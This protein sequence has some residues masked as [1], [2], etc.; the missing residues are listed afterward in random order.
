MTRTSLTSYFI[1]PP[2][3]DEADGPVVLD[4]VP[5]PGGL[6]GSRTGMTVL[7]GIK[8]AL[9]ELSRARRAL[10]PGARLHSVDIRVEIGEQRRNRLTK[11]EILGGSLSLVPDR[12]TILAE[13]GV[14]H[15]R[16]RHAQKE[17]EQPRIAYVDLTK[18]I[19]DLSYDVE[20]MWLQFC[21]EH[22]LP[23]EVPFHSVLFTTRHP[24]MVDLLVRRLFPWVRLVFFHV[25]GVDDRPLPVANLYSGDPEFVT[26]SG[27]T[28]GGAVALPPR[29]RAGGAESQRADKEADER[30]APRARRGRPR[31]AARMVGIASAI[32]AA[33][34]EAVP[35]RLAMGDAHQAEAARPEPTRPTPTP[36][37]SAET[38]AEPSGL[39]AKAQ[40]GRS[41]ATSEVQVGSAGSKPSE[42][43]SEAVKRAP[44]VRADVRPTPEPERQAASSRESRAKA[45]A[46]AAKIALELEE[47]ARLEAQQREE[48]MAEA[49]AAR[50]PRKLQELMP[51]RDAIERARQSLRGDHPAQESGREGQVKG[52]RRL[53]GEHPAPIRVEERRSGDRSRQLTLRRS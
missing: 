4:N 30:A 41:A 1:L 26:V 6:A 49:A 17:P 38:Q 13:A 24:W 40:A 29:L 27:R 37:M 34:D 44:V 19:A 43:R 23:L 15:R 42:R 11:E 3:V 8:P 45:N 20:A 39:P 31:K 28:Y 21:K 9:G 50:H 16:L 7:C 52:P 53:R 46:V 32:Q 36:L 51:S 2:D 22:D 10:Q 35:I 33:R 48:R 12:D 47:K 18:L 25:P 5:L 14:S